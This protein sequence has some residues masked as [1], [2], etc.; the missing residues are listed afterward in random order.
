MWIKNKQEQSAVSLQTGNEQQSLICRPARVPEQ[1]EVP[2]FGPSFKRSGETDPTEQPGSLRAELWEGR[3]N[4]AVG[5]FIIFT[6][7]RD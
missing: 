1:D 7:D 4:E 2:H 6:E 5:A 3:A